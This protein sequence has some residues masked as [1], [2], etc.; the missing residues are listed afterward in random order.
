[1]ER[2]TIEQL[3]TDDNLVV[4]IEN[5]EEYNKL[6]ETGLTLTK[7]FKGSHCYNPRVGRFSIDSSRYCLGYYSDKKAVYFSE[8]DFEENVINNFQLF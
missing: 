3:K 8:I 5:K 7:T 2:Y 4:F 1:M 6:K